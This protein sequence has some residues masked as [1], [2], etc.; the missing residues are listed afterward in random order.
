MLA[1][2]FGT[3]CHRSDTAKVMLAWAP[4]P[5]FHRSD[6]ELLVT[7]AMTTLPVELT[8]AG[9]TAAGVCRGSEGDLKHMNT[10]IAIRRTRIAS[11]TV[12]L[13]KNEHESGPL[14]S[15]F[16]CARETDQSQL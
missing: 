4:G 6:N 8:G 9:A 14:P 10:A 5:V 3:I 1:L 13:L 15:A 7:G 11:F 2:P 16:S 12:A